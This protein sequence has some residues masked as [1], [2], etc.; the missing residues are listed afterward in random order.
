MTNKEWLSTL[1]AEQFYWEWVKAI[2]NVGIWST[3]T[4]SAMIEW[5]DAEHDER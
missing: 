5:L 2:K 3:N 1:T 4:P